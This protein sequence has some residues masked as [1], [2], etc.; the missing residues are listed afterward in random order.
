MYGQNH[1][2]GHGNRLNGSAGGQ[3]MPMMYT[4]QQNAHH[5]QPHVQHHQPLQPDHSS[6]PGAGN[7]MGHHSS[8]SGGVMAN[9]SPFAAAIQN[10]HSNTTRGGQAQQINEHWA[11]QLRLHKD[12]ERANSVMVDQHQ[13]NFYARMKADQ[14]KGVMGS[15]PS[16]AP[17]EAAAPEAEDRRRPTAI[18]KSRQRQDW[19]NL[20]ISGQGL[21]AL[22]PALFVYNFLQELYIASNKLTILPAAIGELRQ[23]TH[24]NASYNQISELPAEI[25]MCTQLK[26][27]LLFNNNLRTFPSELGSLYLLDMLGVEGNPLDQELKQE[28]MERG[29]KSLIS[30]L[31]EQAPGTC[32]TLS[33]GTICRKND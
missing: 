17:S 26:E 32:R 4:Y 2:Q 8:Y 28:I 5:Q 10:G 12:T 21:R 6:H 11:D 29:T 25:A 27:L 23:L 24:L 1:Q 7:S 3:R 20:D 13:P 14:N 22:A 30:W 18:V 19:R 9:T 33:L 31:R 16:Q 15:A